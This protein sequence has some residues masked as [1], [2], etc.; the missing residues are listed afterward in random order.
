MGVH[1]GAKI[2]LDIAY[3]LFEEARALAARERTTLRALVE[4]GL[5]QVVARA[6]SRE[7]FRLRDARFKGAGRG[8]RPEYA[9]GGWARIRR[10][11]CEGR[12]GRSR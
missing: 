2:T 9:T 6:R 8:L 7:S 10:A 5:R 1:I 12:G 3:P 11:A 4:E